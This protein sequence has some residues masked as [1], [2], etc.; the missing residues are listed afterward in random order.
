MSDQQNLIP[1]LDN[2]VIQTAARNFL[3]KMVTA[4][5]MWLGAF[6]LSH[7]LAT[8]DQIRQAVD[9]VAQ[10]VVG[11]LMTGAGLVWIWIRA[12]M[13]REKETALL[14]AHPAAVDVKGA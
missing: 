6:I 1:G 14:E 9:P 10:I 11:A 4:A 3:T 5:L 2:L 12:R 8:D 7:G 13:K